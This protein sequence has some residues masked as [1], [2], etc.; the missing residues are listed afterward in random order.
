MNFK[1]DLQNYFLIISAIINLFLAIFVYR[2]GKGRGVNFYYSLLA[3]SVAAW[4]FGMF[5]YRGVNLSASA[6]FWTKFYYFFSGII[7]FSLLYFSLSFPDGKIKI[8]N[9][10]NYLIIIVGVVFVFS[11]LY[12]NFIVKNVIPNP[13]GEHYIFFGQGLNIWGLYLML[14][15]VLSFFVIIKKFFSYKGI[16]RQQISYFILGSL[17]STLIGVTTNHILPLFFHNPKYAWIGPTGTIIMV[18][19]LAYAIT[20]YHLMDIRYIIKRSTVFTLLV[21]VITA[22]YVSSSY[23]LTIIF[24]NFIGNSSKIVAGLV[25]GILIALIFEPL[26]NLLQN[27]TDRFLFSKEYNPKVLIG[28]ITQITSETLDL[29]KIL[30]NLSKKISDAFHPTKLAFALIDSKGKIGVSNQLGFNARE[31]VLF[32]KGKEKVLPQYFKK[33]GDVYIIS[34]LSLQ[35]EKGEYKPQHPQLL[36]DLNKIGIELLIPLFVKEKLVGVLAMGE[37]K[38]NDPYSSEDLSTLQ[39]ISRQIAIALENASLYEQVTDLNI[40]LQDRVDE[41]TKE[42]RA[43]NEELETANARLRQLD[44]AKTDF[45]DIASHQLRTPPTAVK[46][47]VSMMLQG[48]FGKLDK[49]KSEILNIVYSANEKQISLIEDLLNVAR[50]E[51]GRMEFTF[52]DA[53]LEEIVEGITKELIPLAKNKNLDFQYIKPDKPLPTVKLDKIKIRQVIMNLIE[54][55]IKYTKEGFVKV[56]LAKTDGMIKFCVADSGMGLAPDDFHNLFQKFAIGS[57]KES[58]AKGTG[59]GLYVAKKMIEAH[60]GRVWAES[61]GQGKGSKF[62]FEV[63]VS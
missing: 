5:M 63:P 15:F 48:D 13:A 2:K 39:I 1:L 19:F 6:I 14:Y 32:T 12:D 35:Y 42:I 21:V 28:E 56:S 11:A 44:K 61:E 20:R 10:L 47:Y 23:L 50:L 34:E 24:E 55:A 45:I 51:A 41:Q 22:L 62:C 33:A 17:I 26:K 37:K 52:E 18:A 31:V 30:N 57:N 60:K 38:N 27:L 7:P 49:K 58:R 43:K 29:K 8:K 3:C 54:N 53:S 46:G 16:L 36:E 40:H 4:S 25:V 9:W 59:I